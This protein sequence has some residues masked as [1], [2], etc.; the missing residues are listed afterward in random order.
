[1][2]TWLVLGLVLAA[3]FGLLE[4]FLRGFDAGKSVYECHLP[5]L[6]KGD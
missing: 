6:T 3:V 4:A 5:H 1:M 2:R